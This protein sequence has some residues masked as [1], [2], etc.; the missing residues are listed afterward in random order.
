MMKVKLK[1]VGVIRDCEVEFVPGVNL[2][3][4]SSGSGKSTLLKSIYNIATNEFSDNDISFG[5]TAM[6]ITVEDNNNIVSYTRGTNTK[7]EKCCYNVNGEA[8]VK[9]GR[10]ALPAVSEVLKIGDID[11]NGEKINF[12]F[13]LQFSS[14]F[15][16]LGSQSTLYNVLTYRSSFDIASIN[17][18]YVADIKSN[19]YEIATNEKVKERLTANLESLKAQSNKLY[20]IERIYSDYMKCKHFASA[21]D[22]LESLLN[23]IDEVRNIENE[24]SKRENLLLKFD[25][26]C[27]LI[28]TALALSNFKS[29][30]DL[31]NQCDVKLNDI[32]NLIEMLDKAINETQSII[33][34]NNLKRL[35]QSCDDIQE[36]ISVIDGK[37]SSSYELLSNEQFIIDV[38]KQY[39]FLLLRNKYADI[40]NI[41]T[42]DCNVYFDVIENSIILLNKFNN[43]YTVGECLKQI[44]KER[45]DVDTEINKFD[46]CP[47]CGK[48]IHD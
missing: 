42:N 24:I 5:K 28:E 4:G 23:K 20:P 31:A 48:A 14:P 40:I 16:V 29:K 19:A 46:V 3:V 32:S 44:E 9:V 35:L 8:Y 41:L 27:N 43:L 39:N 2:I 45:S 21:K 26:T 18:Y 33:E 38:Q 17:D 15:L 25:N 47:L 13:N 30:V 10:T 37:C 6:Q 36:I 11:I 12:N 34:L 22:S 7:G 1:N